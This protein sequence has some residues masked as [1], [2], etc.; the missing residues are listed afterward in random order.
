MIVSKSLQEF[1]SVLDF[2][3]ELIKIMLK[4]YAKIPAGPLVQFH[5]FFKILTLKSVFPKILENVI[6]KDKQGASMAIIVNEVI[7]IL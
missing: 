7:K 3:N 6:P 1:D 5:R 2:V 4:P